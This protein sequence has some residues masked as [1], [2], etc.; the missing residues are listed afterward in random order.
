MSDESMRADEN[1]ETALVRE[2]TQRM[3]LRPDAVFDVEHP[4]RLVPL[5][6]VQEL[7]FAVQEMG[8]VDAGDLVALAAPAQVQAFL[9]L[10]LWARDRVEP[11]ET[12][13]WL[14]MLLELDD[15]V[16]AQ[17]I[18]ALDP[19]LLGTILRKYVEVYDRDLSIV[20]ELD[21]AP[22][23]TPDTFFDL[24]PKFPE[25]D[26]ETGEYDAHWEPESDPRFPMVTRLMDKLYRTDPEQARALLMETASSTTSELEELAYRWRSG[27]LADL[28]YEP[29]AEALEILQF[30][31][32]SE[33]KNRLS[34]PDPAPVPRDPEDPATLGGVLLE[35]HG[36]DSGETFLAACLETLTPEDMDRVTLGYTFLANRIAAATLIQ[37]GD[38]DQ[39][40]EVLTRARQGLNLG[41]EY[42]TRRKPEAA[43]E[44]FAKVPVSM[45]FR[46]GHSLTLQLQ[47]LVTALG[48]AGRLSL[49]SR[50]FTL[51]EGPWRELAL[52]LTER[53]P[54]LTCAFDAEKPG[55]G[56]R[57]IL[58]LAD[59]LHAT[60]L[61]EDLSAQWPLCFLGLKFELDWLAP[62]GLEGCRPSEPGAVRLGDLFRTAAVRH[63]QARGL[64]VIPLQ[65]DELEN[66]TATIREKATDPNAWAEELAETVTQ[67]LVEASAAPP[68]RLAR[69]LVSWLAPLVDNPPEEHVLQRLSQP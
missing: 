1:R 5:L 13:E 37:P 27:R 9:D 12:G 55:D 53:F 57:P 16:F 18:K 67:L 23:T 28:G 59:L 19:E 25:P 39:M 68:K 49:A 46:V 21:M 38:I 43:T 34:T 6:P 50:G 36:G 3:R 14:T 42:L 8:V 2:V 11:E 41:L 45:V 61:V 52:G 62:S 63:L 31:D 60:Q 24:L 7:L 20:P 15:P 64:K 58:G 44:V 26:P 51:L 4:E 54:R 10:S 56:F 35:P 69:I 32:P 29:Y 65:A 40:A 30:L 47:R 48:R 17:K 66:A 33:L 22:Y